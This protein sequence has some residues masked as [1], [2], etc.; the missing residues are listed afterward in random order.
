MEVIAT[1]RGYGIS[2]PFFV[3]LATK[4]GPFPR[5]DG[6]NIRDGQVSKVNPLENVLPGPDTDTLG[7][8]LRDKD[9]CHFNAAGL[10]RHA[11]MWADVL[12]AWADSKGTGQ[13]QAA[14]R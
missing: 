13:H 10:L 6:D 9:R 2:A 7:D 1:F 3:A 12:Q 14:E 5:P 8:E 11:A 4:C